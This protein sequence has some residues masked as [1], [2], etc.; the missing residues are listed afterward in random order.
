M[1]ISVRGDKIKVTEAMNNYVVEKLKKI[2][3]YLDE[4]E[5]VSANVVVRVEKQGQ[6]V[7]ITIPLKN[8]M[9]RAEETQEDIYAAVD[10]IVDKIERQIRKN[11][12][13]LESQAKKSREVKGFAIE[14]I[15][16]IEEE[17]AETVIVKRKKVDVKPM[18]EE[19]LLKKAIKLL[20]KPE[21]KYAYLICSSTNMESL[22]SFHKAVLFSNKA[23]EKAGHKDCKRAMYVNYYVKQQMDLFA[24]AEPEITW[25]FR[26]ANPF[27]S[28]GK[29]NKALGMSQM[30]YMEEHGFLILIGK[31]D[32]Y[33]KYIE[34]FEDKNTLLIYSMWGGYVD[35]EET[36]TYDEKWGTLYK[37]FKRRVNLHT[38]GHAGKKDL[39]EM[40]HIVNPKQAIIPIHTE[41]KKSYER[42]RGA[43]HKVKYLGDGDIYRIHD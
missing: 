18:S 21:N 36:D 2:D 14:S 42:L 29:Y 33:K 16:D 34:P 30:K 26:K 35:D 37:K 15:E 3:K 10:T 41:Y 20:K 5:A 32:A 9:L 7:E 31:S 27:E 40:I 6:K 24:L 12:T 28:Q 1:K 38:S 8:F 39:E 22:A 23:K 43:E 25:G 4:P 17:E 13:K 11:K 19:E